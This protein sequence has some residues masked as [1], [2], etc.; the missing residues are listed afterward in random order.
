M[1]CEIFI[2]VFN[3]GKWKLHIIINILWIKRHSRPSDSP[4]VWVNEFVKK[5]SEWKQTTDLLS[6]GLDTKGLQELANIC[7]AE[8]VL[9]TVGIFL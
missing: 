4:T 8:L 6:A 5:V 2:V 1:Y 7:I 9:T 3:A